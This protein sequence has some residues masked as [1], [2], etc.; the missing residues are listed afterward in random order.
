M[1]RLTKDVKKAKR[2]CSS[3]ASN[4][5]V[6]EKSIEENCIEYQ[7]FMRNDLCFREDHL[8][9]MKH[10]V[11]KQHVLTRVAVTRISQPD[12]QAVLSFH[13][14]LRNPESVAGN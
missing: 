10:E 4:I 1:E 9:K 6:G 2:N 3:M 11:G 7:Y 13:A 12:L 5:G 14:G 8:N